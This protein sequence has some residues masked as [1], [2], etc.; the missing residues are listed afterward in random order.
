[1]L[2]LW[3]GLPPH[4]VVTLELVPAHVYGRAR[5]WGAGTPG[6]LTGC[7]R[8]GAWKPGGV[9]Q[10]GVRDTAMQRCGGD[11]AD[12]SHTHCITWEIPFPWG[13]YLMPGWIIAV[14]SSVQL[15][16]CMRYHGMMHMHKMLWFAN[17]YTALIRLIQCISVW[18]QTPCGPWDPWR[19]LYILNSIST[20]LHQ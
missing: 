18:V 19:N 2:S 10:P 17:L 1:M 9:P 4:W 8:P 7:D 15:H 16:G 13:A 11:L 3:R 14:I 6:A 12:E 5:L 20:D